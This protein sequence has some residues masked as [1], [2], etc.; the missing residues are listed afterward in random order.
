MKV[1]APVLGRIVG[2]MRW[3]AVRRTDP[4]HEA[5]LGRDA[6]GRALKA[7]TIVELNDAQQLIE[8]D[9]PSEFKSAT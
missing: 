4:A 5:I 9:V 3:A 8:F 7:T 1:N 2:G 6:G